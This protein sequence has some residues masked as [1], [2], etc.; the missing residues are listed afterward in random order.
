MSSENSNE[1]IGV[2]LDLRGHADLNQFYDRVAETFCPD[3]KDFGRN[4]DAFND[5]LRGG[6]KYQYGQK[7]HIK[8]RG[9]KSAE[10]LPRW[11]TIKEILDES[12]NITWVFEETTATS[13]SV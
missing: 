2:E 9:K 7:I 13:A 10:A 12:Q 3:F 6:Y 4:L 11:D 8:I 1:I 5:I